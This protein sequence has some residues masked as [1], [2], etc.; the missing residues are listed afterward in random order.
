MSLVYPQAV[1]LW[2]N[3]SLYFAIYGNIMYSGLF[4]FVLFFQVSCRMY[5]DCLYDMFSTYER[6]L[7]HDTWLLVGS[8]SRLSARE[9]FRFSS[10][11]GRVCSRT[12]L[13][14]DIIHRRLTCDRI[15]RD[16]RGNAETRRFASRRVDVTLTAKLE[17]TLL[18]IYMKS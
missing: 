13:D 7:C 12:K 1:L 18:S 10:T 6:T 15:S 2:F 8:G 14:D 5:P 9:E 11:F 4:S 17:C 3:G 16:N